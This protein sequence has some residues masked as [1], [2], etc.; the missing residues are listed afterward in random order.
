MLKKISFG[1]LNGLWSTSSSPKTWKTSIVV[2]VLKPGKDPNLPQSYRPIALTSCVCKLYERMVNARL[3]W[4]L[5]SKSLLS[6]RQFGFRK[7]RNTIDPL[8]MISREIQNSFAVQNQTIAVF[9]DLE[10]A[11]DT[12]W[13]AGILQQL[14]TWNIGGNMFG[15]LKDF[16]SDRYLKV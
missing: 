12:T 10:K 7:N 13:R 16:L 4:Y 11:Y 2:P 9:F 8:L 1:H 5:E 6:N 3:V 15:C 14:A